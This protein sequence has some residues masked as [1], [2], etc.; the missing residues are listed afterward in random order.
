MNTQ[1]VVK[2]QVWGLRQQ[3]DAL[4]KRLER[5]T[6]D[7]HFPGSFLRARTQSEECGFWRAAL[8]RYSLHEW[9]DLGCP[10]SRKEGIKLI[11]CPS[12]SLKCF[13]IVAPRKQNRLFKG[14]W[15]ARNSLTMVLMMTPIGTE[16]RHPHPDRWIATNHSYRLPDSFCS[17]H[18]W[19]LVSFPG[20]TALCDHSVGMSHF[21]VSRATKPCNPHTNIPK[22]WPDN[23]YVSFACSARN[24]L[25]NIQVWRCVH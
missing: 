11:I 8:S 9:L 7:F 1:E 14:K 23:S 18:T 4:Q 2:L 10:V 25:F 17:P 24:G 16:G 3:D 12:L 19:I 5:W 22:T 13:V 15:L 6:R 21:S 20:S